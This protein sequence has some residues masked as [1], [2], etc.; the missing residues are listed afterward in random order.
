[1]TIIYTLIGIAVF[2]M[3]VL[4]GIYNSFVYKNNVVKN[5][6]STI[7]VLLK[8]RYDLI[9]NL[10]ETVKGYASH[11]ERLFTKMAELRNKA[12]SPQ[13]SDDDKIALDAEIT[14]G[15][16]KL[17]AVVENYPELK[18]N[19][20]YLNLQM[21]LTEIE[22]QISAARRAYNAAVTDFNNSCEMFPSNLFA[23]MFGFKRKILFQIISAERKNVKISDV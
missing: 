10:V 23:N 5:I 1:M 3:I 16:Q 12:A 2:F 19:E 22:D 20:N 13:I 17:L 9:P 18:A 4:A 11:E 21:T 7:D 8:K 14:G 6:F 15:M